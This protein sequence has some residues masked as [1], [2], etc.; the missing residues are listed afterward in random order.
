M[1]FSGQ[2][3]S[4]L[5]RESDIDQGVQVAELRPVGTHPRERRKGGKQEEIVR[6]G[7]RLS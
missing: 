6:P 2:S 5:L 7:K 1:R 4:V 3:I